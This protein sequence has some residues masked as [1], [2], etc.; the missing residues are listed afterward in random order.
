MAADL[1][2]WLRI[3]GQ[4]AWQ[5]GFAERSDLKLMVPA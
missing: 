4:I 3:G 5:A 1:P 2:E